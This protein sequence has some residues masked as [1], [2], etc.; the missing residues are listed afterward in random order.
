MAEPLSFSDVE[1]K[2]HTLLED[3]KIVVL[4]FVSPYCPTLIKATHAAPAIQRFNE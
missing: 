1:G 3:K 4:V 2:K